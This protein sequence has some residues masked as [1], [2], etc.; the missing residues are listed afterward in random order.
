MTKKITRSIIL[1]LIITGAFL[2]SACG[3][4]L[5]TS[6][7]EASNIN[8]DND[9]SDEDGNIDEDS[10]NSEEYDID[11]NIKGIAFLQED[12]FYDD[13]VYVEIVSDKASEIEIYYTL[14]GSDPDKSKN[15]YQDKIELL[16][17]S[18]TK[19]Y[20]LKAK[21]YYEDG[22]ETDTLVHTYFVGKGVDN[23]FNTL[24]F[25]VTTDPYNLYDYEYGILIEGKLR[26]EYKKN[27]PHKWNIDPP[28]PA[29]YNMR[30]RESER[31]IYLEVFEPDGRVVISQ[32]AGVRAYGGWSRAHP[33]K[34]IRLFARK[35]YDEENNK[36]RYEFFPNK[37]AASGDGSIIRNFKRLVLRN[38]G[39]D[40]NHGFI[41]DELFQTLAGQAGFKDY[42]AVRPAALFING[43]YQGQLWLHEVYQ[44]EYFEEHYGDHEGHFEILEGGETFKDVEEDESNRYAIRDYE[45]A[46]SYTYEDL[47][48][49]AV[50]EKLSEVIDLENYMDYYAYQIFINNEDWPYNNYKTYRYYATEGEEYREA[51]FDGKWRYMLH[52]L[53]YSYGIYG[54]GPSVDNLKKYVNESGEISKESPLLSQLL[55]REDCREYFITRTLDFINGA[56]SPDNLNKVLDEMH[57][58]RLNELVRMY[59]GTD[60]LADWAQANQLPG[61]MDD[62]KKYGAD[63]VN[64]TYGKYRTFFQLGEIYDL[65]VEVADGAGVRINKLE[66]YSDFEGRYYPDY[67]TVITALAPVGKEHS[68]WIVNGDI[69]YNK[70]L[71]INPSTIID[72]KAEVV[73]VLKDNEE[74]R[75]LI[76]SEVRSDGDK[77]YIMLYNPYTEDISLQGYSIT[78]NEDEAGKL[79]FPARLIKGGQSLKILGASNQEP[80]STGMIRASFNLKDGET[81]A[82]YLDGELVDKVTIPNIRK[83][84][85]YT[86]DMTTMKFNEVP[87]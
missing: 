84:N 60:F 32:K 83:G 3:S 54:S 12:Y 26:D 43:D 33:Q 41:R 58:S 2:F 86:R 65:Y 53:D 7:G 72:N 74:N 50:F 48:D 80:N 37:R 13:T 62:I 73:S 52:D 87:R 22:R 14:D 69:V 23:R 24:V 51:P 47:T 16:S 28:A 10:S 66:S 82:L 55:N 39:N 57:S 42:Q 6:L 30:G 71:I 61:R 67:D 85:I 64:Y 76:I 56:L 9:L 40:Y 75:N 49:D 78:D 68:H 18:L 21:G 4:K 8:L 36:F 79:I 63:R 17:E 34:S 46:Y 77:D 38:S 44:D 11:N 15:L 29:N 20:N 5:D 70:E 19:M 25:S 1:I 27:N 81:V 59:D 31:D 35:A 45:E